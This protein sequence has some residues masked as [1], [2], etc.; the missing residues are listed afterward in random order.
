MKNSTEII[1]F[2][3]YL[4]IGAFVLTLLAGVYLYRN[5]TVLFGPKPDHPSANSASR[6]YSRMQAWA[7]WAHV[8]FLTGAFALFLH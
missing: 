7:V 5:D 8:A 3:H 1:Q 6:N 4:F 2:I